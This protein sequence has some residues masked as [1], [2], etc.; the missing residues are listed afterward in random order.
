MVALV[1]EDHVSGLGK[2]REDGDVREIA[3]RKIERALG[4]LERGELPLEPGEGV[5]LAAEQTRPG[6]AAPLAANGVD[7]LFLEPRV[8]CEGEV[9][10]RAEVDPLRRAEGSEEPGVSER[11]LLSRD[12]LC[13]RGIHGHH[14]RTMVLD[15][16]AV[17]APAGSAPG[18]ATS[19]GLR[20]PDHANLNPPMKTRR[21]LRAMAVLLAP[22][23]LS[24][25]CGSSPN[26][27]PLSEMPAGDKVTLR[28]FRDPSVIPAITL[29]DLDG[30][31]ISSNDWRGK[32]TIVNF[33]ATWCPPCRAEIPDLVALQKKYGDRLQ[34]IGVSQDEGPIE[35]VKRFAAEHQI[36]Y[37][38]VMM[39][40]D[41]DR[42]FPGIRALP[43]SF[44]LDREV[45]VVQRHVGMLNALM[46]E[47]ET[48][49]ARRP[50]RERVDRADR[51][52]AAGAARE[53]RPGDRDSRRRPRAPVS[54][55][56][57]GGPSEAEHRSV[58]VR[59]REHAREMPHRRSQVHDQP[60]VG[61]ESR[62][63]DRGP[64]VDASTSDVQRRASTS[65]VCRRCGTAMCDGLQLQ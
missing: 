48:R 15:R 16:R 19:M 3:G 28:F 5:A 43:T 10:V 61:A 2:R 24:A 52:R 18:R 22:G 38:I 7:H 46:T 31:S 36:N 55:Q 45:R 63:G 13:E 8:S 11:A 58:H 25:A 39:T 47:Q 30:R 44:V 65:P 64:V 21:W 60:A 62:S 6:A 23:P 9:V 53:C 56:A 35:P 1:R 20:Q 54:R 12:P 40:P 37:P 49:V 57:D 29:T 26:G 14:Y 41:L 50:A 27:D 33:W 34:I 32:V 4:P 17:P 51:P 59:L 42:V